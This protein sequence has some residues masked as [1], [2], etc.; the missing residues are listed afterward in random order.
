[1]A[2]TLQQMA[3]RIEIDDLLT[4]YSTAIDSKDF[5]LLDQVFTPDAIIDYSSAAPGVR[6]NRAEM[7][8]WLSEVLARFPM[9]QHLVSNKAITLDGDSGTGR[10]MF[11]NPMGWTKEGSEE[12]K[13]FFV[14]GYYHDKFVRTPDGW[15]IVE[16]IEQSAWT[17]GDL[18]PDV[19]Q[20]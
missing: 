20:G 3:D 9:T 11:Y 14:G 12:L 13:L 1:M 6:G 2:L 18:P 17:V 15:R 4:R 8:R 16:R 7:K 19:P 5:D 10:T